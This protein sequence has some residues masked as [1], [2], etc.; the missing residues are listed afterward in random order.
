M[1]VEKIWAIEEKENPETTTNTQTINVKPQ[2]IE[3][4]GMEN[5]EA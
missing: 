1:I 3:N 5:K 2:V 4:N